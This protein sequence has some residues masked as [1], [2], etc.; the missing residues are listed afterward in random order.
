MKNIILLI[1]PELEITEHEFP[2]KAD[3]DDQMELIYAL[4]GGGC[5]CAEIVRPEGLKKMGMMPWPTEIPGECVAMMTD[6]DFAFKEKLK[7]NPMG[8]VLYSFDY[9]VKG[10]ILLVG[11]TEDSLWGIEENAL[12]KLKA[13]LEKITDI[14][15]QGMEIIKHEQP[16]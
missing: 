1:T 2:V 10:N 15:K 13:E 11:L 5:N 14:L 4:I 8:T 16:Q 9:P 3:I 6:E 7:L 12:K